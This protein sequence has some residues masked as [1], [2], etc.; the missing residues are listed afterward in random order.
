MD[1]FFLLL[2]ANVNMLQNIITVISVCYYIFMNYVFL[3]R[4]FCVKFIRYDPHALFVIVNLQSIFYAEFGGMFIIYL[5][6]KFHMPNYNDLSVITLKHE[7]KECFR[8]YHV[9]FCILK[10]LY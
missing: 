1:T 9:V 4:S 5:H 3:V 7:A 2:L 10:N 6:N 8:G